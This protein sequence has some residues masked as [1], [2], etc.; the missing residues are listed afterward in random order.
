MMTAQE[1][2]DRHVEEAYGEDVWCMVPA[3]MECAV[4]GTEKTDAEVTVFQCNGCERISEPMQGINTEEVE[5]EYECPACK[6]VMEHGIVVLAVV[7][8]I[9]SE[10]RVLAKM[11]E[12]AKGTDLT[13]DD[14]MSDYCHNMTG[15]YYGPQ[16]PLFIDEVTQEVT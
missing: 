9:M 1:K 12:D 3:G 16:T 15:G 8:C 11:R 14:I 2:L 5:T 4:L 13:D 7:R 6:K 10:Q